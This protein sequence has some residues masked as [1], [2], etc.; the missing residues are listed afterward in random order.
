M[1]EY[2]VHKRIKSQ[3]PDSGD[4]LSIILE[5]PT[6]TEA[7]LG[8]INM[9]SIQSMLNP[10]FKFAGINTSNVMLTHAIQLKPA[11]DDPQSFFHKRSKYKNLKKEVEWRSQF[12]PTQ[13][14]FLKKEYEQDIIR[15]RNEINEYNPNIIIAMGSISLWALC[16]LDKVGSYRGAF[17]PADTGWA[18]RSY[19]IMPTYN[20]I[21]VI[22]NYAFRPTVVSDLKK[23]TNEINIPEF[24]HTE[25]DIYI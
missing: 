9:G 8:K 25:R 2:A 21:A 15:L 10:M 5:Y 20:P 6:T 24:K 4:S 23:A 12:G 16:G 22:K 3:I 1:S 11:Q 14:G 17:V 19:K 7:R 18:K 13:F